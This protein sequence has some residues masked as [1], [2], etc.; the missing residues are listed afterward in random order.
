MFWP[1]TETH[2][3][4]TLIQKAGSGGLP[5][6]QWQPRLHS[7]STL[8]YRVRVCLSFQKKQIG[9]TAPHSCYSLKSLI[10]LSP[11]I[12][13]SRHHIF[14]GFSSTP[15]IANHMEKGGERISWFLSLY[16]SIIPAWLQLTFLTTELLI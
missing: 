4:S 5:L 9:S 11:A 13:Q 6:V 14:L 12:L 8:G 15:R 7:S 1:I 2:R 10:F 3:L 16:F